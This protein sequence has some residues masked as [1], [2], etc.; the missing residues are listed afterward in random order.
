MSEKVNYKQFSEEEARIYNQNIEVIR[1]NVSNGVK[2]D[3]ACEFINVDDRE[4]KGLII[5]DALKVEIAE[6]HYGK[7]LPLVDVSKKLGVPMARLLKANDEM[8]EDVVNTASE[9]T[10]SGPGGKGPT[11]H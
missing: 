9:L 6:L 11:I 3:L 7:N 10:A 5:D 1:S 8:I 2:F 4:L